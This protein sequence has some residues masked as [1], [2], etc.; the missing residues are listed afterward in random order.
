MQLLRQL[1]LMPWAEL[2][3][4]NA[5]HLLAQSAD[6]NRER[7]VYGFTL[8][9]GSLEHAKGW[10]ARQP[11]SAFAHTVLGAAQNALMRAKGRQEAPAQHAAADGLRRVG[12]G[13]G[14]AA[15]TS[16]PPGLVGASSSVD[17]ASLVNLPCLPYARTT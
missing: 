17:W 12:P 1:K 6:E 14:Q 9:Q 16:S 11:Q 8:S 15:H 13:R 7:L 5:E 2:V 3:D 4:D 10:V